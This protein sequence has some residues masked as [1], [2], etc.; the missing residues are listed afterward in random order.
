MENKIKEIAELIKKSK[1][2]VVFTGAGMDTESNIPDFRG[3]DGIWKDV[4]PMTVASVDALYDNYSL[5]HEFYK[6]RMR[7]LED[8]KP[9]KGHYILSEWEE[10]GIIK[11]IATQN[12]SGLHELAGNKNIAE[13]H[14]SARTYK[15]NN[16]NEIVSSEDFLEKISCKNCGGE[17]LRPNVTLFG[18]N[19]PEKEWNMALKEVKKSDLLI[20]IGTS[21]E[22]SPVNQFPNLAGG[23]TIYINNENKQK[24]HEFDY[25][26]KGKV[27]KILEDLNYY[28][29]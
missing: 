8:Y 15:C 18:E 6:S 22:V 7:M 5:F 21:L 9:H 12:I 25:V 3:R 28:I 17:I 14:G 11:S 1:Y 27:G 29:K 16:C 23:K 19:L 4:D 20:V 24:V 26:V 2:V 13:L 10:K